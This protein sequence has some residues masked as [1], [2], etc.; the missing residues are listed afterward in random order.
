[1]KNFVFNFISR[2]QKKLRSGEELFNLIATCL[3]FDQKV[4]I[5]L[6][7]TYGS[8]LFKDLG[9]NKNLKILNLKQASNLIEK[10]DFYLEC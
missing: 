4:T 8:E 6:D 2:D 7:K 1:M 9:N 5:I 3:V 10:S